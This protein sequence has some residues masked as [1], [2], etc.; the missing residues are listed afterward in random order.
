MGLNK[1]KGNM[2]GFVT[3][4]WNA[5]KGK[6]PIDCSYCYMKKWGNLKAPRL[7]ESEFKTDLGSGN[8]IFVGS[9]IDMW[10]KDIPEEWIIKTLEHIWKYPDNK[11]LFQSKDP[12]RFIYWLANYHILFRNN[13]IF[14]T[15]IETN[16][17]TGYIS[18]APAPI[19]RARGMHEL[20]ILKWK[21][22]VTIEPV[23]DFDLD[24]FIALLKYT[25]ADQINIGAVTGGH[26]LPEPSKEKLQTLIEALKP[27]LK[28]NIKRLL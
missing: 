25:K 5:I 10:H 9:S 26:K 21:T 13:I 18:I 17:D 28:S 14:A 23:L 8:F 3:H 19:Y 27:H 2:Y 22:M 6:C 7:D 20:S 1:Q 15:T 16:R 11:Y 12:D 24:G 4:T